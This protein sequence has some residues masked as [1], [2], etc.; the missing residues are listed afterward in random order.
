MRL[1]IATLLLAPAG[2]LTAAPSA[3]DV[4]FPSGDVTLSGTLFVPQA[5]PPVA[6]VVLVH[7]AGEVRRMSALARLLADDGIAVLTY[8]K[9]GVGES[10]GVYEGENNVSAANL[11]L[12]AR[13]AAAAM[14]TLDRRAGDWGALTGYVGFSQAGWIVPLAAA[15]PPSPSFIAFWSGPVCR[16]GEELHFSAWAEGDPDFWK[17]HS[18]AD[19]EARMKSVPQRP[20]DV[21]PRD[22]L[23]TLALPGL[24]LFGGKDNSI[25]VALSIARLDGLASQG[26]DYQHRLLPGEGH[27]LPDSPRQESYRYMV[28]WIRATAARLR[29]GGKPS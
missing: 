16:V 18:A 12:L 21:D 14:A 22:N 19:V 5:G 29:A 24:W 4:R 2:G 9:R 20:G 10:G 17:T 25:P 7:G 8:D 28:E 13:D 26:H 15:K 27:V 11:A 3:E 1:L 23:A 6:A